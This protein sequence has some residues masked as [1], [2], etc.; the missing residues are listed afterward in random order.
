MRFG[1][2][3]FSIS[4][5]QNADH[6]VIGQTLREI[7]LA[8]EVGFDAVWLTEH[9]FDGAVAYADPVVFGAAVAAR[10][11]RMLIGFAVVE[12]ALHHPVRLAVQTS[13]LD[14][15]SNGRLI[16]G[17][18][19]GSAYNEYEYIGYG[20]TLEQGREM[21]EEAEE[22]LIKA[23]TGT[24]V[25]H[26]GRFWDVAFPGLRP[27]PYQKP[28]PPIVRA[29]ISEESM[30]AMGQAGRPVLIGVQTIDTLRHRF[31][32]YR[33]ALEGSGLSEPQIEETLDQTWAQR[34][35][36]VCDSD[37]QGLE[38]AEAG[39]ARYKAHLLD[40]RVR[41]NPGGATPPPPGTPI[42]ASEMVEHAFLAGTPET[43]AGKME[44]LRDTGVRNVLLNPNVG[45]IPAQQVEKSLRLFGEKVLPKFKDN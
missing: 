5:D 11:K 10:T 24:D 8:E 9:H 28:H 2:F 27:R 14:N 30:V 38:V 18:G 7:E 22:L 1:S 45:Q 31:G 42:P 21:L 19:R 4:A 6:E 16:M 17:I 37:Q 39:L 26:K 25:V 20:I 41:F 23:W 44:E 43:V 40:A 12:M 32:R 13:L 34:A 35:L 3:V 33:E 15:L 36:F 29:C